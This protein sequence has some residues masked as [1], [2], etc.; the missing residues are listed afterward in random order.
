[1][2]SRRYVLKLHNL[3]TLTFDVDRLFCFSGCCGI[4]T[5][6]WLLGTPWAITSFLSET[7]CSI[8]IRGLH[9]QNEVAEVIQEWPYAVILPLLPLDHDEQ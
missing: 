6:K 1:M 3:S 7:G 2:D 8:R 9:K 4:D 5:L